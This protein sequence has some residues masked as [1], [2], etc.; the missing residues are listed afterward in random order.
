M[1]KSTLIVACVLGCAGL[2]GCS[3]DETEA[4]D[5]FQTEGE[6]VEPS[7]P[8]AQSEYCAYRELHEIRLSPSTLDTEWQNAFVQVYQ[9]YK[10]ILGD[11]YDYQIVISDDL[12][13]LKASCVTYVMGVESIPRRA[14]TGKVPSATAINHNKSSDIIHVTQVPVDMRPTLARHEIGH[15]M[16]LEHPRNLTT[17]TIMLPTLIKPAKLTCVDA[18]NLCRVWGCET[19][20]K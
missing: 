12:S 10:A 7:N 18:D 5:D 6:A 1:F 9:E 2:V 3:S 20:C 17:D 14:D 15:L 4:L 16:G 8:I 19:E 11:K 13:T